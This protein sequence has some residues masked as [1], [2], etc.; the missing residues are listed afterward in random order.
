MALIGLVS[1][2]TATVFYVIK[3]KKNIKNIKCESRDQNQ[4]NA[5]LEE[6]H[7]N[8]NSSMTDILQ[9]CSENKSKQKSPCPNCKK[10][11]ASGRGLAI[12][13]KFCLSKIECIVEEI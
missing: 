10:M 13:K 12:H 4:D 11:Y 9:D 7:K 5:T 8:V 6:N 1:S 3:H 2:I